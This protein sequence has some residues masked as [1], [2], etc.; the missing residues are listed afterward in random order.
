MVSLGMR[1]VSPRTEIYI[2]IW[3]YTK[4]KSIR[5]GREEHSTDETRRNEAQTAIIIIIIMKHNFTETMRNCNSLH[6][7][8][9]S[10]CSR[11]TLQTTMMMT[12]II[13]QFYYLRFLCVYYYYDYSVEVWAKR[14]ERNGWA[15]EMRLVARVVRNWLALL[16]FLV[17]IELQSIFRR[18][19]GEMVDASR[20]RRPTLQ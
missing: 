16:S 3:M 8:R 17:P 15:Y 6:E 12:D 9:S 18:C 11:K 5:D 20:S 4:Y 13:F 2:Y 1:N 14:M 7:T 19:C 10:L